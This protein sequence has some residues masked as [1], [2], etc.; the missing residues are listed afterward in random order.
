MDSVPSQPNRRKLTLGDFTTII[1][2]QINSPDQSFKPPPE[3]RSKRPDG[4]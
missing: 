3:K 2:T 1:M 4:K